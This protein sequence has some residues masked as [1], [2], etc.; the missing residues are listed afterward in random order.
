MTYVLLAVVLGIWS[1]V[2]WKIFFSH[3]DG[4]AV[5]E[6]VAMPAARTAPAH[7]DTLRLDYRD[8]FL[9]EIASKPAVARDTV[10]AVATVQ[11]APAVEPPAFTYTGMI[12][13][14]LTPYYL[15]T[16]DDMQAM[17]RPGESIGEYRLADGCADSVVVTRDNRDFCLKPQS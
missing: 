9:S 11:A 3:P 13:K 14:G 5:P 16:V 17:I 2:A 10:V 6:P 1:V 4:P 12:R 8:P 7:A 15:F